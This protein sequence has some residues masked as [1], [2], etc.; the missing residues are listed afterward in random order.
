MKKLIKKMKKLIKT[1]LV[2][3]SLFKKIQKLNN[4]H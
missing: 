2:F 4:L 1:E 3:V